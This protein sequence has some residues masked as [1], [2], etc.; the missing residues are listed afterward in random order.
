MIAS[1]F[2]IITPYCKYIS[3]KLIFY[4]LHNFSNTGICLSFLLASFHRNNMH[5]V[6]IYSRTTIL[7][8]FVQGISLEQILK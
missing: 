2:K 4:F 1:I 6:V 7:E 5:F 3:L 8:F